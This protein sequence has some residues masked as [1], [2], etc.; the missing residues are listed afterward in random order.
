MRSGGVIS[1]YIPLMPISSPSGPLRTYR[2]EPPGRRSIS[3]TGTDQPRGPNQC[4]TCAG[5]VNASN[6]SCRGASNSR[7]ISI[8]R[9]DGVVKVV[10][11]IVLVVI[12]VLLRLQTVQVLVQPLVALVPEAAVALRPLRHLTQRRRLEL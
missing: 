10:S 6:T 12:V 5:L 1:L 3:H 9:S 4:G 7:V 2:H 11:P 8:S